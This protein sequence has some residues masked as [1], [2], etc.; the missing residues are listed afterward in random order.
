MVILLWKSCKP[1]EN[2]SSFRPIYLLNVI[3][4]FFEHLIKEL[5]KELEGRDV[6]SEHQYGFR[7]GRFIVQAVEEVLKLPKDSRE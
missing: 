1:F 3:G 6:L 2:L 7:K 5:D 4:E